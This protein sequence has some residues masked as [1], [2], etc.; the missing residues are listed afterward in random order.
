RD[1]YENGRISFMNQ[2]ARDCGVE[3]G[4]SVSDAAHRLLAVDPQHKSPEDITNRTVMRETDDGRQI[5]CLDSIAFGIPEVDHRNV[6]VAGGHTAMRAVHNMLRTR[7]FGFTASDGC[8]GR[9]RSGI[10]GM[11]AVEAHGLAVACVDG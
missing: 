5:V 10:Q 3:P 2:L 6:L 4:M 7:P 11:L 9:D 1:M 8:M